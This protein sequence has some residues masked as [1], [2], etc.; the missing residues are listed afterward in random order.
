MS[1]RWSVRLHWF[2]LLLS[3]AVLLSVYP[4]TV[5]TSDTPPMGGDV[6]GHYEAFAALVERAL[7]SGSL[8]I[9]MP[10][11]LA[12]EPLLLH[13]F[14]LPYLVMAALSWVLPQHVAFNV[15]MV[16]PVL[17][18]PLAAALLLR[19]LR[20]DATFAALAVLATTLTLA[21]PNYY[22]WGGN[23]RSTLSGQF[24]HLYAL[25]L[26]LLGIGRLAVALERRRWPLGAAACF[27]GVV[28][29]HGY[30]TLGLPVWMA[31]AW[32]MLPSAEPWRPR[33][34][35]VAA[36]GV[37]A[38]ALA[39]FWWWPMVTNA[40]N[41]TPY[42]DRWL[43][44]TTAAELAPATLAPLATQLLIL[45]VVRPARSLP[46]VLL[47]VPWAGFYV[48]M[49]WVF[50]HIGLVDIRAIPQVHLAVAMAGAAAMG[51]L[52]RELPASRRAAVASLIV[53]VGMAWAA[54]NTSLPRAVAKG[55]F[56]S[57]TSRPF[58][59]ERQRLA[60]QLRG[61]R[62]DPR[63]AYESVRAPATLARVTAMDDLGR[64]A[65][66]ATLPSIFAQASRL[67]RSIYRWRARLHA[68]GGC[69]FATGTCEQADLRGA[70]DAFPFWGVRDLLVVTPLMKALAR[71]EPRLE[72][73][74]TI[75]P[76]LHLRLREPVALAAALPAGQA[77]PADA[78]AWVA[79]ARCRP[80]VQAGDDRIALQTDC[81]GQPHL[82]RFGFHD[83][84]AADSG[85]AL[86]SIE[87]G[88]IT[89]VPTRSS[90]VLRFGQRPSWRATATLSAVA[91]LAWWVALWWR[92]RRPEGEGVQPT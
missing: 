35:R 60:E 40:P 31:T 25:V 1:E 42:A 4:A 30:V 22:A 89:V 45:A 10:D 57:R 66:R 21:V 47:W 79:D 61:T 76:W 49:I 16:L 80:R 14:P 92:R 67:S 9:W 15:G 56:A 91:W 11:R 75:G 19:W 13:Y 7:P 2:A 69:Y 34:L 77:P 50:P 39:A 48:A 63:V 59:A 88:F 53:V 8:R 29:S 36:A 58:M 68:D 55:L 6:T 72:P 84:F 33:L 44:W 24:A 70:V 83:S 23:L 27:A 82:L 71:H 43:S 46:D 12:G 54:A 65:G 38:L 41:T 51:H 32:L 78:A 81:P 5:L 90:I 52:V 87:P 26:M 64:L 37:A 86:T 17:A 20:K 28:L 74:A 73:V 85:D 3:W 62:S 18:L